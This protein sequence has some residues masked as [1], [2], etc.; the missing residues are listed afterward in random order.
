MELS[1]IWHPKY[2]WIEDRSNSIIEADA[3][4]EVYDE[5]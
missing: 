1:G 5:G 2:G 4:E 3:P